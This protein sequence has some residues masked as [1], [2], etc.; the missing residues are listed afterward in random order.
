MGPA[1][2]AAATTTTNNT[3][4][5]ALLTK[6]SRRRYKVRHLIIRFKCHKVTRLPLLTPPHQSFDLIKFA[7][8]GSSPFCWLSRL[9]GGKN[10]FE[11]LGG[12]AEFCI[13]VTKTVRDAWQFNPVYF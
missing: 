1:P 7:G 3:S 6:L 2:P 13:W 5:S 11:P 4:L 8:H 9:E 10:T 12:R